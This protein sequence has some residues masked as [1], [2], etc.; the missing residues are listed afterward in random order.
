MINGANADTLTRVD[1]V[2]NIEIVAE[3]V[4]KATTNADNIVNV[5]IKNDKP[6][7]VVM[8][9]DNIDNTAMSNN[10]TDD[11]TL[12][13][14]NAENVAKGETSTNDIPSPLLYGRKTTDPRKTSKKHRPIWVK[15]LESSIDD[16][17]FDEIAT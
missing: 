12:G 5:E 9:D 6:E 16:P 3:N 11:A 17:S 2:D 14:D 1:N 7:E 15:P 8:S 10:N 4:T 13:N